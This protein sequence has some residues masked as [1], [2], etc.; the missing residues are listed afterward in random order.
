[1]AG[2]TPPPLSSENILEIG[3]FPIRNT[4]LASWLVM[5]ILIIGVLIFSKNSRRLI[6]R[7]FQNLV[8]TIVE[9]LFNFFNAVTGSVKQTK[10]FFPIVATIFIFILSAN[11]LGLFPGFGPLGICEPEAPAAVAASTENLPIATASEVPAENG[12]AICPQGELLLPFFRSVNS[13]VNMTLALAIIAVI[14]IQ[15]FGIKELGFFHYW[16][17]FFVNPFRDFIGFFVGILE[18]ISEFSKLISFSFRL[19][20]NVFAGEVLLLVMSFL[21]PYAVP[22][23]FYGLEL[24]VAFVQAL[25]FALLTLVFMTMATS[26]HQEEQAE[27]PLKDDTPKV[28]PEEMAKIGGTAATT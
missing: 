25:V 10:R 1:M 2:F 26:S 17:K 6:P 22:L 20:G 14:A 11:L 3:S 21:V 16:G 23:P 7:G 15:F 24:F 5:A 9:G 4:L 19:F 8:E 13:D 28:L 12:S 27:G 18:L